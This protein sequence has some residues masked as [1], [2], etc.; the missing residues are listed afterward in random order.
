MVLFNDTFTN[1][2]PR[3]ARHLRAAIAR[4]KVQ[5]KSQLPAD[6]DSIAAQAGH[7]WREGKLTPAVTIWL[8]MLQVLNGNAAMTALRRLGGIAMQ[9]SSYCAARKRLPLEL[10]ARLFDVMSQAAGAVMEQSSQAL[11]HGRRVLMGDVTTFS[12]PDTKAL[13]EHFGYPAGQRDGLG[14]P[15]GRLLGVID[16]VTGCVLVAM[17]CPLFTHEARE[18]LT[19]HPLLKQGDILVAD[20]GFCSYLQI[21]R[22]LEHGVDVVMHLHQRRKT[23]PLRDCIET[24]TKP[25]KR[26][27][28]MSLALWEQIPQTLS[29]RIVRYSVTGRNGR[30]RQIYVATTLLDKIAYP[31]ELIQRLY[32]HRWNIETFFN[33]LKTHAKM[34]TLKCKDVDGV[35]K[36]LIMYL[37]VWNLVRMT[38]LKF[39]RRIGVSVWRVSFIDTVRWL[40]LLLQGPRPTDL[41]LLI[42][43]DRPGRWEPRKLKRRIKEYDLLTEPRQNLKAKHRARCA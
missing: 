4:V 42:N 22:L 9:A 14:F 18:M 40:C 11:I 39:A 2:R 24:W 43:P 33:Q 35:I 31:P 6:V 3:M 20:R 13:R 36:E 23:H 26:P 12:M 15:V 19:L 17:G 21:A 38:M 16:A 28:W 32:G 10:F 29:I 37:I 7:V 25:L 1:R 30:R 41:D 34:N 5:I 27:N 8:F